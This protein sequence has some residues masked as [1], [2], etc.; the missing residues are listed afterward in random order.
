ML[1]TLSGPHTK[2]DTM[3]EAQFG[4]LYKLVEI[5]QLQHAYMSPKLSGGFGPAEPVY[6]D[7][8]CQAGRAL[9]LLIVT[10]QGTV[11]SPYVVEATSPGLT[12][13][14][15]NEM[16]RKRYHTAQLDGRA[17]SVVLGVLVAFTC[18]SGSK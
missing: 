14:A 15:I 12:D 6:I 13:A 2:L 3:A 7:G 10:E 1:Y 9:V 11:S 16:N 8:Q 5:N 18:P 17:V 4:K